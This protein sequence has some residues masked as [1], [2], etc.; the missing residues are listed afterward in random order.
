M[1]ILRGAEWWMLQG[2]ML[3]VSVRVV[4]RWSMASMLAGLGGGRVIWGDIK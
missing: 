1:A 4:L 2:R 3:G